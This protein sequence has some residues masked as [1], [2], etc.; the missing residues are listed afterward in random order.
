[1][2]RLQHCTQAVRIRKLPLETARLDLGDG[3]TLQVPTA[4]ETLRVKV[5]LIVRRL[6]LFPRIYPWEEV[7]VRI[8]RVASHQ[9]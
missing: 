4:A 5:F 6:D 3:R 9:R 1:M 8:R 7:K 2:V